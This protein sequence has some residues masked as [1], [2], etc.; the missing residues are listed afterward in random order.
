MQNFADIMELFAYLLQFISLDATIQIYYRNLDC[1]NTTF[2]MFNRNRNF[3]AGID[4]A[5]REMI[6]FLTLR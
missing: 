5:L 1:R 6:R 2:W 4:I 3:K